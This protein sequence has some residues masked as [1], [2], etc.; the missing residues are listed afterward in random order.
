MTFLRT[1]V[2]VM[3][4]LL[5]Y[6]DA[7]CQHSYHISFC[8]DLSYLEYNC[9]QINNGAY[10]D[11]APTLGYYNHYV[12]IEVSNDVLGNLDLLIY[13]GYIAENV[14]LNDVEWTMN[15]TLTN[16]EC[17]ILPSIVWNKNWITFAL[18]TTLI[19]PIDVG[20][21][22]IYTS[23]CVKSI[24]CTK[25]PT[26]FPTN[27][28]SNVL[29]KTPTKSPT[30]SPSGITTDTP[31]QLPS[32]SP[33]SLPSVIPTILPTQ[34]PN[35]ILTNLPSNI[36]SIE[37][38]IGPTEVDYKRNDGMILVL[39]IVVG[40]TIFTLLLIGIILIFMRYK[41]YKNAKNVRAMIH[42]YNA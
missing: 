21:I 14:P 11:R 13:D 37:P 5:V 15:V 19:S 9:G 27:V 32:L 4:L 8:P 33:T 31:T 26:E 42:S 16:R 29:T 18:I 6:L 30:K 35:N 39:G 3:A 10:L 2:F 17:N 23:R 24:P 12:N 25:S 38:T 36:P 1:M 7:N 28:P 40:T 22:T 41:S 34:T 20:S